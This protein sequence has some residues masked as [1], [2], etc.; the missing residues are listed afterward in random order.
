MDSRSMQK[1]RDYASS[2]FF[3]RFGDC[4]RSTDSAGIHRRDQSRRRGRIL[5]PLF[6]TIPHGNPPGLWAGE[7]TKPSK[8]ALL[9]EATGHELTTPESVS[10]TPRQLAALAV[11]VPGV[12][13]LRSADIR[14]GPSPGA[15]V[16]EAKVV[17]QV[18][19]PSGEPKVES[20][21]Q[22]KFEAAVEKTRNPDSGSATSGGSEAA[23]S[24]S[25]ANAES[26]MGESPNGQAEKPTDMQA[27]QQ[28][29]TAGK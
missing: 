3:R 24:P 20:T 28:E 12:L 14:R 19:K 4:F 25:S 18:A 5:E 9:Q 6:A 11:T 13:Y 8:S 26:E 1:A 17:E 29:E 27:S 16:G 7:A 23:T 21:P 22:A 15:S 2:R 10:F